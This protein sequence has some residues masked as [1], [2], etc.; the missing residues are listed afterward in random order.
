M[1]QRT[2]RV[3]VDMALGPVRVVVAVARRRHRGRLEVRMPEGVDGGVGVVLPP[4]MQA[5]AEAVALAAVRA[6]P[7]ARAYLAAGSR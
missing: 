2:P 1:V 7:E 3:A 5:E 4:A 6:D